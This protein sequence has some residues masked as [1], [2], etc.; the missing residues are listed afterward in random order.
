MKHPS[1][2]VLGVF[3]VKHFA[4]TIKVTIETEIFCGILILI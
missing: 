2:V 1:C 4:I 3:H